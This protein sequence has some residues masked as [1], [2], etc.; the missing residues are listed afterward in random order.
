MLVCCAAATKR[1]AALR[2]VVVSGL[3]ACA[4]AC[5]RLPVDFEQL[6]LERKIAAYQVYISRG[7]RARMRPRSWISWHGYP[8]ATAMVD[9]LEGK[10]VGLPIEE[11]LNILW[12]I[13]L[14]GCSL[15][16]TEAQRVVAAYAEKTGRERE[17]AARV[18]DSIRHDSHVQS[19]D[20]LPGG[21]CE[22]KGR[23]V[24]EPSASR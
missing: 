16:G 13:Q 19:L 2:A 22:L 5:A 6:P 8:A 24:R 1:A 17:L 18:L 10:R 15:G 14:R 20:H 11:V 7:G 9:F 23:D 3:L 4:I 21:P 12:N